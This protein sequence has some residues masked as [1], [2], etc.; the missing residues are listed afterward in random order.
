MDRRHVRFELFKGKDE[1]GIMAAASMPIKVERGRPW[2][3]TA[4]SRSCSHPIPLC[5]NPDHRN[6]AAQVNEAGQKPTSC[7]KTLSR[8]DEETVGISRELPLFCRHRV[9]YPHAGRSTW[10]LV[11]RPSIKRQIPTARSSRSEAL[12]CTHVHH[13]KASLRIAD[14]PSRRTPTA[15][16]ASRDGE[17]PPATLRYMMG[18][19]HGLAT[20]QPS[21]TVDGLWFG[22]GLRSDCHRS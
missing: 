9:G 2:H 13:R 3:S 15:I 8:F 19:R 18:L 16:D 1:M 4:C 21:F 17:G 11:A 12:A 5:S 7:R 14:L 20:K 22:H 10:R 6:T